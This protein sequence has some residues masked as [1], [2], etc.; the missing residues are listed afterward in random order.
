MKFE[1]SLQSGFHAAAYKARWRVE[2]H[3]E[4]LV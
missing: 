1:E 2:R 4:D 3:Y